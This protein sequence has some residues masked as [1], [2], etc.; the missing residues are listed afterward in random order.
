MIVIG[1]RLTG[2]VAE[3]DRLGIESDVET[4]VRISDVQRRMEDPRPCAMLILDDRV[5]ADPGTP[6]EDS[7]WYTLN[8]AFARTPRPTVLLLVRQDGFPAFVLDPLVQ[9][10]TGHG[11]E[12]YRLPA[13]PTPADERAAIHWVLRWLPQTRATRQQ[14]VLPLS[15]AG[16]AGKTTQ[17]ANLA[18]AIRQ[19][20]H[21]V[22]VIDADFAN[23]SLGAFFKVPPDEMRPFV[24]LPE[25][26][27]TPR[28]Q[29]PPDAVE[30][31]IYAH[32][33]G[34]DLLLSG[35]GLFET[36]DMTD[37]AMQSLLETVRMLAY[38]VVVLDAGP[39]LKARPYALRVLAQGGHGVVV[40]QPGKKERIGAGSVL[41]LLGRLTRPGANES[42]LSQ[43]A[44]LG[45]EAERG[46]ICAIQPVYE[47]FRQRFAITG[48]GIVPRDAALISSVAEAGEFCSVFDLAPAS[49]YCRA[50]R[51]AAAT[52]LERMQLAVVAE[53]PRRWWAIWR[54][55]AA[56]ESRPAPAPPSAAALDGRGRSV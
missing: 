51:T 22:L 17:I 2:L 1:S 41:T 54:R 30:R 3:I 19:H 25:E 33:S 4:L 49:R 27:P 34:V 56:R 23:G 21:R 24:T 7:V 53:P 46:S 20:G 44:L 16:G 48:L 50:I 11:G 5:Y 14:W 39:D 13:A 28:G 45:V 10:V 18:L 38:D 37:S 52:L 26:Y 29:Y 12:V 6:L 9:L 8:A 32:R 31:R 55:R 43:A 47:E 36:S 40:L 35:R 42:L 15:S